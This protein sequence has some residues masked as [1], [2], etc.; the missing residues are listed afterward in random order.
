MTECN[1]SHYIRSMPDKLKSYPVRGPFRASGRPL[2]SF[3]ATH[4]GELLR[5]IILPALK[6]QGI[7]KVAVAAALGVSRQTLED[8]RQE[9]RAVTAEMALRLG[10]YLR[11]TPQVWLNL[12]RSYDLDEAEAR[13]AN[14]LKAIKPLPKA[15]IRA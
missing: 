6:K 9:R 15:V 11:T 4:P 13:I 10:R 1:A 12:Q 2:H 14:E 5:K 7:S 3:P 8:L